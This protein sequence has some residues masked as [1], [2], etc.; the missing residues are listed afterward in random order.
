MGGLTWHSC[1]IPIN[2]AV[3]N[4]FEPCFIHFL[5]VVLFVAGEIARSFEIFLAW[6]TVCLIQ[7]TGYFHVFG[8]LC[9]HNVSRKVVRSF[10]RFPAIVDRANVFPRM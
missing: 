9:V 4:P 8:A 10:E 2:R 5:V 3:L 7:V 1:D 6:N